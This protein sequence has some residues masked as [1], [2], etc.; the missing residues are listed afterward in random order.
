MGE[1]ED[2]DTDVVNMEMQETHTESH[3]INEFALHSYLSQKT[4]APMEMQT[5]AETFR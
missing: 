2:W 4:A 3:Q 1:R 5:A